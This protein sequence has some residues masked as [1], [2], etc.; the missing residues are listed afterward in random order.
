M[1]IT[2][3]KKS[4]IRVVYARLKQVIPKTHKYFHEELDACAKKIL[5]VSP[6][7]TTSVGEDEFYHVI[8]KY[9]NID[10]P[11]AL[12][13]Y[14][15]YWDHQVAYYYHYS[16]I[17]FSA[18]DEDIYMYLSILD[19]LANN[20]SQVRLYANEYIANKHV[21]KNDPKKL[22]LDHMLEDI[23]LLNDKLLILYYFDIW[24]WT[25]D[26]YI[27]FGIH[28]QCNCGLSTYKYPF[29]FLKKKY[30]KCRECGKI[31]NENAVIY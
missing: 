17:L 1:F 29:S 21:Y 6:Y 13:E 12:D 10:E 25:I 11:P 20:Q 30:K 19:K 3:N 4:F 18:T 7:A 31:I 23:I 27:F 28:N 2:P 5:H 16:H 8:S 24:G 9:V 22:K 15:Q 14:M 26:P